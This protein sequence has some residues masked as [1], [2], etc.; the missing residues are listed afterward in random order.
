[1]KRPPSKVALAALAAGLATLLALPAAG[2]DAPESL[3]PPG[4]GDPVPAR[5]AAPSSP[6]RGDQQDVPT[7]SLSPPPSSLPS[8]VPAGALGAEELPAAAEE[9]AGPVELPDYARRPMDMVGPLGPD[10]TGLGVNAFGTANGL[11]L[12]TLMRRVEAPVASRWASILLRRALLSRVPSPSV[13][14]PADWVAERA[15]LLLRMGEADGARMLVQSVDVDRYTPKLVAVAAQT[16]LATADPA[17]LCALVAPAQAAGSQEPIWSL[18]QAMCTALSGDAASSGAMIDRARRA[19]VARGIDLLLA[20]KVVGA[21]GGRRQINIEWTGVDQLTSWRFGVATALGVAVPDP[22][23]ATVGPHVLAWRARSA[24]VPLATR[25]EAARTAAALGVLSN[26]ALVDLYATQADETD[27]LEIA[28]TP[29]GR[30]RTAYVGADQDARIKA[31]REIWK[32]TEDPRG[33][34]GDAVLTARAAARIAPNE[35]Y[36][37]DA[38]ALIGAM[39]SAG[40]DYQADRWAAIVEGMSA[41]SADPAW[42]MLAV[43]TPRPRVDVSYNRV[44]GFVGRAERHRAQLLFAGLAGLGRL[45]TADTER[46]AE[47]L[48]VPIGRANRWSQAIELAA[49]NGQPGTVALLA[50]AGLQTRN[51]SSVPPSYLYHIVSALRRVGRDGDARMIA[52]EA[53]SRT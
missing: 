22:L 7:L 14:P 31:L 3:L 53:M 9:T 11:F 16:A 35:D 18:A 28:G 21:G 12:S 37:E 47:E 45:S 43:G 46:L 51:W 39:L 44:S 34:Y 8:A 32:G 30:L 1:M 33:R 50:A 48:A 10:A 49:T 6:V 4:F 27:A 23:F 19:R 15:W 41:T 25:M 26:A 40:L 13:V 2:Q 52:A 42:A 29:A 20:E 36:A 38:S 24:M 17:G 5:E